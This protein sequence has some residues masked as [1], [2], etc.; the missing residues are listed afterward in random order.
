MAWNI[1]G[2]VYDVGD[3][4]QAS[5]TSQDEVESSAT[6]VNALPLNKSVQEVMIDNIPDNSTDVKVKSVQLCESVDYVYVPAY[7]DHYEPH[8]KRIMTIANGVQ[9]VSH[10]LDPFA[11]MSSDVMTTRRLAHPFSDRG[12]VHA[13]A[14]DMLGT[15]SP[16][17]VHRRVQ[18]PVHSKQNACRRAE[19]RRTQLVGP[20]PD[21]MAMV[22]AKLLETNLA[23]A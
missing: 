3:T 4:S 11:S 17:T 13:H 22:R 12:H 16:V 1:D 18:R 2:R 6:F 5:A 20:T 8:P 9:V 14:H 21:R 10:K 7:S 23:K 15:Q 19:A